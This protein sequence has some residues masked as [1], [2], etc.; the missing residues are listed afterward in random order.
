MTIADWCL[1]VAALMPLIAVAPAKALGRGEYDN[2]NPR[3]PQ[4]Y[5]EGFRSRAWGA[6]LNSLEAFPFFAVAVLLC[7][8]RGAPQGTIDAIAV[9]YTAARCAYLAAY[10]ADRPALRS[11]VWAVGLVLNISLMVLPALT[12][13]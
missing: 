7:E 12:T 2:A 4:F 10:L 6:H 9:A 8:M 1:L 5:R 13:A 11:A 3:A